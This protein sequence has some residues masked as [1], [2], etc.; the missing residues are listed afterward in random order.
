MLRQFT[1]FSSRSGF[2]WWASAS[3]AILLLCLAPFLSAADPQFERAEEK[4]D[5]L[6]DGKA[7]PGSEILFTP[8][9]IEAWTREKA[10]EQ[11]GDA[12]RNPRVTLETGTG[13]GSALVDF[14]KMREAKGKTT[15][16]LMA[17]MLQ[18]ERPLTVYVRVSSAAG[19]CTVYLTR[20]ELSGAEISGALLDYLIKTFLLQMYPDVRLGEPFELGLNMERI[21]LK[22]EGVRVV[23]KK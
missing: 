15:N 8:A 21:E 16:A 13:A 7:S 4:L 9:E 19:R 23:M 6:V 22:P 18:G 20:V 14:L 2:K 3:S 11:V 17:M 12:F 5:R 1:A 10:H